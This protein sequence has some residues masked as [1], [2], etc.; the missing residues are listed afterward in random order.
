MLNWKFKNTIRLHAFYTIQTPNTFENR[1]VVRYNLRTIFTIFSLKLAKKLKYSASARK[2]IFLLKNECILEAK[3]ASSIIIYTYCRAALDLSCLASRL[4]LIVNIHYRIVG[5]F[6]LYNRI[7]IYIYI[8]IY[9][10][11]LE[12]IYIYIHVS[13]YK[14]Y[15]LLT[16]FEGHTVN[17]RP[18]FSP[19]IYGP[20]AKRAG[21]KS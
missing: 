18:S 11:K 17:Y 3:R 2:T 16:E 21:H 1:N 9:S 13:Q 20:K 12:H 8:Y 14:K 15:L 10:K 5:S 7:Y 19:S 6:I 4:E